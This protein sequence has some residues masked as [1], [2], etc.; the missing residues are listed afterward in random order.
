MDGLSIAW[1]ILAIIA[2]V[3]LFVFWKR[4]NSIWGGLTLGL[5]IGLIIAIF[6]N[7]FNWYTIL[8]AG[9]LGVLL[10]AFAELLSKIGEIIKKRS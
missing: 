6:S 3:F 5:V 8:K 1:K 7:K 4:K 2:L 10:G 9:I